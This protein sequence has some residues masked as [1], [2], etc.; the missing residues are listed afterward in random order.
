MPPYQ[1]QRTDI[2]YPGY[3]VDS[4]QWRRGKNQRLCG[5]GRFLYIQTFQL[6]V[7]LVRIKQLIEQQEGRKKEFRKTLRVNP[8]RITITSIDEQLLQ[9]ALK[10]IEEHI[11]NSEYNVE[12]LS[13]DMGMSR[14]NLYRKL[15]AITGQTPT[16]FI[17]T[18]RL[19]RAAQLLQDGKLNVSEVA[20]RVGFSSSSYFTKCFKE[21]FGVLPTTV[22]RDR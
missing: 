3:P 10:L 15:Q 22:F 18:I 20:D 16:E 11:D 2:A 4:P 12:Q 8:S 5:W 1:A 6:D 9:K 21:Q 7:L 19:K 13:A 17:R 14:M